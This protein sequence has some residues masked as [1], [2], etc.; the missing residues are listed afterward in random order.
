MI[1]ILQVRW[2]SKEC[3]LGVIFGNESL[4]R[5]LGNSFRY[6]RMIAFA[7]LVYGHL[8]DGGVNDVGC[9]VYIKFHLLHYVAVSGVL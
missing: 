3:D 5:L 2:F 8:Y 1:R 7:S 4:L 6:G 9:K